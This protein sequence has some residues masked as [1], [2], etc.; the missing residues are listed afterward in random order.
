M[1]E[2][3]GDELIPEPGR[4]LVPLGVGGAQTARRQLSHPA[5]SGFRPQNLP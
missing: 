5:A 1:R 4:H 3:P 2:A